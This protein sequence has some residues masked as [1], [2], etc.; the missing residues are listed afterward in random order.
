MVAALVDRYREEAVLLRRRTREAS[1][2]GFWPLVVEDGG[3]WRG[4]ASSFICSVP[5]L[6]IRGSVVADQRHREVQPKVVG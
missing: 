2:I 4:Q 3:S 1:I 5:M 6:L